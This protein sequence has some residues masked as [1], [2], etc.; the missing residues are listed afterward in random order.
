MHGVNDLV[1][2]LFDSLKVERGSE[3]ARAFWIFCSLFV[4]VVLSSLVAFG[5][6]LLNI[7]D[8]W[9]NQPEYSHGFL[10]PLVSLYILWEKRF[11]IVSDTSSSGWLGLPICLVALIGL[12]IGEVSAL[13]ILIHYSFILFLFGL[14]QL[15]LGRAARHTIVPILL[16]GFAVPLPY[17]L[18]SALTAKLQLMS[19]SFG[20]EI[21]KFF[22]I[23]V[24]LSGNIIDMGGFQL[25]VVEACSGLRYLFPLASIGFIAAYFY[26]TAMWKRVLIFTSTIPI[27][28]FMNSVRI[29]AT[30]LLVEKYGNASAE[31]FLHDFEGWVVF[32]ISMIILIAEIKILEMLTSK[33]S[34]LQ[35]FAGST[36]NQSNRVLRLNFVNISRRLSVL[37]VMLIIFGAGVVSI[38]SRGQA[39]LPVVNL[40]NF[41]ADLGGWVG[42]H[43]PVRKNI[44]RKL[45][46][47]DFLNMDFDVSGQYINLFVAYY[48]NQRKGVSPHSPKVC[49]PG[50]GWEIIE[51]TRE[52]YMGMPVNRALI[53]NGHDKQ[54]VYYWFIERGQVVANEYVKKW[55]LFRDS[56]GDNRT[57]G[58]LVRVVTPF[59]EHDD[60]KNIE[61][62]LKAFLVAANIELLTMLP[63]K[64][65]LPIK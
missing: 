62:N 32:V 47:S 14:A 48:E 49:M 29:A 43:H 42:E 45:E 27:T 16:L 5:G 64:D 38:N 44:L 22:E 7:F 17:F 36:E 2:R 21:I 60:L 53:Q 8:R 19:S 41:P 40:A 13:Y 24:Y 57:D 11:V 1:N 63:Q 23:P 61:H 28:I 26:Q 30:G 20:V 39:E 55:W 31:G 33:K 35:I 50:G 34:L 56:I 12:G 10:I 58:S 51:F 9:G 25:H 37:C 4:V 65:A 6:G 3:Q 15:I 52:H 54:L 18:E 46:T 59:S